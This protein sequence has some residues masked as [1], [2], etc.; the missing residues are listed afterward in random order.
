MT[1]PAPETVEKEAVYVF[2]SPDGKRAIRVR[3]PK[4]GPNDCFIELVQ[5]TDNKV[6]QALHWPHARYVHV[7]WNAKS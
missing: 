6:I 5:R 2:A 4:E 3:Q 7:L 1:S